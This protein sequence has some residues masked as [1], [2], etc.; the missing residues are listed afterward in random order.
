MLSSE[1]LQLWSNVVQSRTICVSSPAAVDFVRDPKDAPFLAA[2]IATS[3]D[4]LITGDT[5]LFHAQ[6]LLQTR[7]ISVAEFAKL[8]GIE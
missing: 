2:A 7:V 8:F 3:A 5:D 4:Y 1:A 6:P